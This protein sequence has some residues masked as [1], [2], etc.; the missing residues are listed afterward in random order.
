MGSPSRGCTVDG[1]RFGSLKAA[2]EYI[3][4]SPN[5]VSARAHDSRG[6]V[7]PIHGHIL[8]IDARMRKYQEPADTHREGGPLLRGHIVHRLGAWRSD[9]W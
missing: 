2:A 4:V 7:L 3:G 6:P 8:V 1:L 9:G 5:H